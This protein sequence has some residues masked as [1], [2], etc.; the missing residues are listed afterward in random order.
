MIIIG[1]Q[2]LTQII[3]GVL[4]PRR[5]LVRLVPPGNW[6]G[7]STPAIEYFGRN[8]CGVCVR[9]TEIKTNVARYKDTRTIE[10]V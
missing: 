3:G 6:E 4:T 10:A 7:P 1:E 9:V 5:L 8:V 2:L